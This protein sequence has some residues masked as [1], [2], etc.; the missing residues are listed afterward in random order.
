MKARIALAGA[1]V[2]AVMAGCSTPSE[3]ADDAARTALRQ[4]PTTVPAPTTTT[5]APPC[6]PEASRSPLR[7]LPAP[8]RMPS[9]TQLAKIQARGRLIVGVDQNTLLFGNRDPITGAIDGLDV[10]LARE[11]A[12]AIFGDP[13][14][15]ELRAVTTAQ[16]LDVVE[17]GAVDLV[18]SQITVTCA[19]RALVD[20]ST[21]YYLAHQK[22]L[23]RSGDAINSVADLAGRRVCATTGSTSLDNLR[24]LVPK[25]V[26]VPVA[27]RSDCLVALEEGHV[28]AITSD[29][30]ILLG[31]DIQDPVNT[32]I[33]PDVL[34]DE[35]YG[36]GTSKQHPEVG[37]FVNGVLDAMRADGRLEQLYLHYLVRPNVNFAVP[38]APPAAQYL[39]S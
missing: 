35:P 10:A 15:V 18:A 3:H 30:T 34:D 39:P 38:A 32:R 25:A 29:D 11:M 27:A 31:F 23:V 8:H 9:G 16:R 33:L 20:L 2:A 26:P 24:R 19:R 37:R 12:R 36:L 7:P 6:V 1:L 5:A 14:A 17:S 4:P 21:V 13:N 22:V 28:D